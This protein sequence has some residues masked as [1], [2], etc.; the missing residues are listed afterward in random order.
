MY[1]F[2]RPMSSRSRTVPVALGFSSDSSSLDDGDAMAPVRG[3][4]KGDAQVR[5]VDVIIVQTYGSEL[6]NVGQRGAE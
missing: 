4:A 3:S 1:P 6:S 5:R 2:S